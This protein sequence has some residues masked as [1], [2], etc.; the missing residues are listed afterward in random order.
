MQMKYGSIDGYN[1]RP[2]L[3]IEQKLHFRLSYYMAESVEM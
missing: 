1:P 2:H 3:A